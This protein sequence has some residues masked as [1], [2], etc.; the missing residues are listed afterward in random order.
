M[1]VDQTRRDYYERRRAQLKL[2]QSSFISHYKEISEHTNPRRGRFETSDRN[3]GTKRHKSIINSKATQALNTSRAGLF[4]GVMSP[5]RPWFELVAPDPGLMRFM[6][7]KAWYRQVGLQM[8]AIFNATNLY[9]MAPTMLGELLMFATGC[10]SHVDDEDALARFFT[11]TAGSYMISQN[12]KFEV[13]TV[14]RE[15]EMTTEQMVNEFG[16]EN[17]SLNVKR[18]ADRNEWASWHKVVHVVEPND[19]FRPNNPLA[20]FK[21]FSSVK[22]EQGSNEKDKFLNQGGFD[23]FP[24]YCPR[25]GVTGEDVYGTD[26]PGMT[27]LGDVKQLQIQEKRKAQAIDKMVNPPLT[28]PP[29]IRN[30][31]VSQLAGGLTIYSGDATQNKLQSLY[32]VR[33]NLQDLKEDMAR[34]EGRID[35]AYFVDLFL[36][37]SNMDGIQ[38]RNELELS[39]RNAERLL[40]LGPVLERL[41][42]DFL[43]EMIGRT[44]NQMVKADLLPPA[45]QEIQDAPLK[46]EYV[47]SLAQ[48]Q[49]AVDTRGIDRLSTFVGTLMGAGLSDGKKF[50]GD[51]A[52]DEYASLVG[53]PPRLI[54]PDD[55]LAQQRQAEAEAAQRV[56]QLEAAE[57]AA[58]AARDAG[59]VDLEGDN[60][61]SRAVGNIQAAQQ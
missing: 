48:A 1:P 54:I 32:E 58:R 23:D 26:C 56:Q 5:T 12:H 21:A 2:E 55:Q 14:I 24:F 47:S 3:R 22:Y 46:V 29:S 27:T 40:Q 44:F 4:A 28:G 59:Q 31:P 33:I 51:M 7:V 13:D 19:D 16:M 45:P 18:A 61:V 43:D 52:I 49:R 57:G 25:W 38:P 53:T 20:K 15:Y 41:Q 39:E 8:R 34:V 9:T 30:V 35:S 60:V 37:I 50:N 42:G 10:M 6:P 36:A 17:L 11:H